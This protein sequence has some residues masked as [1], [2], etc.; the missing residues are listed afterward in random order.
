MVQKILQVGNSLGITLP[1]QFATA[2]KLQAGSQITVTVRQ[3]SAIVT[4]QIAS[5]INQEEITDA[6]FVKLI[7]KVD[8]RYNQALDELAK[9]P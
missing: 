8:S 4:P 7:K 3:N 2:N 6:Q 1:K 9:L 5:N